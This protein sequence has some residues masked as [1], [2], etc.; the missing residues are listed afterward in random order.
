[1]TGYDGWSDI[2]IQEELEK[3]FS[4]PIFLENDANAGAL[5]Q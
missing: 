1:M 4:I 5:A 2:P 3:K